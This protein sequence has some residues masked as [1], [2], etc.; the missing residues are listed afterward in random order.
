ATS[1]SEANAF[2]R[3]TMADY[4]VVGLD[5]PAELA[6]LTA[7]SNGPQ[8]I[9]VLTVG[10]TPRLDA[11]W[12][13]AVGTAATDNRNTMAVGLSGSFAAAAMQNYFTL[14]DQ[15]NVTATTFAARGGNGNGVGPDRLPPTTPLG[16]TVTNATTATADLSWIG[17]TD[18]V[19]V[20]GYDVYVNGSLVGSPA[21]TAFT[22]R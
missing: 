21:A 10:A 14:L 12:D 1:A 16:G 18:N 2:A 6:R 20:S 19:G 11:S 13:R 4:V 15:H 22:L 3:K 5:S 8:V 7:R 9:G 17:S